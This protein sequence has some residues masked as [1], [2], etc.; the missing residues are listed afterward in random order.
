[1]SPAHQGFDAAQFAIKAND[2]L[3]F[4]KKLTIDDGVLQ[5]LMPFN[6]VQGALGQYWRVGAVLADIGWLARLLGRIHRE[7]RLREQSKL[8]ITRIPVD[9][10]ADA[11]TDQ[12]AV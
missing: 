6:I 7:I 5:L 4:E 8:V 10:D 9:R 11:H 1:M 3:I 12:I 2:R